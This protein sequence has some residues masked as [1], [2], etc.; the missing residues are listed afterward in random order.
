MP[1]FYFLEKKNGVEFTTCLHAL[2]GSHAFGTCQDASVSQQ[3][4]IFDDL[5][6]T[7]LIRD[8]VKGSPWSEIPVSTSPHLPNPLYEELLSF[9]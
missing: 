5:I 8:A 6:F 3:G 4:L 9:K 7:V 1:S 2:N